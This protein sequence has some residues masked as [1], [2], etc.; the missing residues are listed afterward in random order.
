[1]PAPG[2][3]LTITSWTFEDLTT[4]PAQGAF[5]SPNT[6]SGSLFRFKPSGTFSTFT[7]QGNGS[8]KSLSTNAWSPGD[9]YSFTTS[10]LNY[11]DIGFGWDQ[12]SSSSGPK[13]FGLTYSLDNSAYTSIGDFVITDGFSTNT[14]DLSTILALN[15]ES[16]INLRLSVLNGTAVNG[17]PIV[18][19]GTSRIDNVT[20][21][22]TAI[23]APPVPGPL[24]ILGAGMAFGWSRKIRKRI[25]NAKPAKISTSA[26]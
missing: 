23:P 12:R 5:V 7:P 18:S 13:N 17:S 15:N 22:G 11:Q 26:T 25:K 6:G 9:Y 2:K 14:V 16:I 8:L 19:T 20:F 10:T 1:L 21:T 4:A 3:A 24:P